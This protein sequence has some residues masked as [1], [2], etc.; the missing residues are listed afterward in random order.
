MWRSGCPTNTF[1]SS[2]KKA[3]RNGSNVPAVNVRYAPESDRLLRCREMTQWAM[4]GCE[5]SQQNRPRFDPSSARSSTDVGMMM[6]R[7]FALCRLTISWNLTGRSIGRSAGFAPLRTIS[8]DNAAAIFGQV[9]V[10]DQSYTGA[11]RR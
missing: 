4:S 9:R 7:A 1:S 10:A 11:C 3:C 6:P 5:Q 2:L 8:T